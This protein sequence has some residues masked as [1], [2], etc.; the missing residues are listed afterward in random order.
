FTTKTNGTGL[1]LSIVKRIID[2]H[3]GDMKIASNLQQ[4]TTITL[5]LPQA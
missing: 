5:L 4:G 1:G 2:A 3:G